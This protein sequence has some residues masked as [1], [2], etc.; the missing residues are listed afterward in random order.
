MVDRRPALP[1]ASCAADTVDYTR[2][3]EDVRA[4]MLGPSKKL[5]ETLACGIAEQAQTKNAAPAGKRLASTH[6][7]CGGAR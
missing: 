2:V 7:G 5:I 4:H 6:A 1:F 3:L